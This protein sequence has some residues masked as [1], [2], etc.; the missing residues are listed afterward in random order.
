M[1]LRRLFL[2]DGERPWHWRAVLRNVYLLVAVY[3]WSVSL[4]L[5]GGV[6]VPVGGTRPPLAAEVVFNLVTA[7]VITLY[8]TPAVQRRLA[9]GS[10]LARWGLYAVTVASMGW[11]LVLYV[12]GRRMMGGGDAGAGGGMLPRS[13]W[14]MAVPVAAL[15]LAVFGVLSAAGVSGRELFVL[16]VAPLPVLVAVLW[17][18]FLRLSS[19]IVLEADAAVADCMAVWRSA[20]RPTLRVAES[21]GATVTADGDAVTV[22]RP[23]VAGL[24]LGT[25]TM[26]YR[27]EAVEPG[28]RVVETVAKNG[29]DTFRQEIAFAETDGGG[30]RVTVETTSVR[31]VPAIYPIVLW[32]G[33]RHLR[34]YLAGEPYTLVQTGTDISL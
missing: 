1:R 6:M 2:Y 16:W 32:L 19:R 14:L 3:F 11:L 10:S 15:S 8:W 18:P 24:P 4:A 25:T 17:M 34:D 26:T 5:W 28:E 7:P 27:A 9:L 20:D 30:T 23:R 29:K 13:F 22:E 33:A 31:R 21:F 12:L